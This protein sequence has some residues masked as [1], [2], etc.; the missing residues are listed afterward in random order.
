MEIRRTLCAARRKYYFIIVSYTNTQPR[1]TV[2][3][4]RRR[5][6]YD[7]I[8]AR[9]RSLIS[10][11]RFNRNVW[12]LLTRGLFMKIR[13]SFRINVVNYGFSSS[14]KIDKKKKITKIS[15][16]IFVENERV[17]G[18]RHPALLFQRFLGNCFGF[19]EIYTYISA[20][21]SARSFYS[22]V[23]CFMAL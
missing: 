10:K 14:R 12:D 17:N 3:R 19:T 15:K 2:C 5:R 16:S 18:G 1:H 9:P 23:C 4:R 13:G 7:L 20:V 22:V 21:Y 8:P 6:G 11:W